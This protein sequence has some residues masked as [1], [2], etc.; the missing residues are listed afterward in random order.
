MF[1]RGLSMKIEYLYVD[2]GSA[3]Y[4]FIGTNVLT[5]EAHTTD[6]FPADLTFHTARLGV[7][8]KF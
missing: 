5:G 8:F 3:D 2:L 7:N 4:R 6:S 1:W